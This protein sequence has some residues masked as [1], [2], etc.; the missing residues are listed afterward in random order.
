MFLI[1]NFFSVLDK[2]PRQFQV[3]IKEVMYVMFTRLLFH[4]E[5]SIKLR[6][7]RA[8]FGDLV[9]ELHEFVGYG[10]AKFI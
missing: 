9:C 1:S 2:T 6:R 7:L 4:F 8:N 5:D 3:K 10:D